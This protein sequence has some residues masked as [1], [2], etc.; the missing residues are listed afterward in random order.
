[1]KTKEVKLEDFAIGDIVE[2]LGE[3]YIGCPPKGEV[4]VIFKIEGHNIAVRYPFWKNP[5]KYAIFGLG[6]WMVEYFHIRK[7]SKKKLKKIE[8]MASSLI[9]ALKAQKEVIEDNINILEK[10]LPNAIRCDGIRKLDI[11]D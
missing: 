11:E 2:F 3:K 1:M 10:F 7:L 6:T 5:S 4:G 8:E 9:I